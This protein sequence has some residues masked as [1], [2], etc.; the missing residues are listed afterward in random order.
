MAR[1][2]QMKKKWRKKDGFCIWQKGSFWLRSKTIAAI[3]LQRVL[4]KT[5][6]FYDAQNSHN[7]LQGNNLRPTYGAQM[8][9]IPK[10]FCSINL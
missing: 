3:D 10:P 9:G 5:I 7:N 8:R 6:V 4:E 1:D 2:D